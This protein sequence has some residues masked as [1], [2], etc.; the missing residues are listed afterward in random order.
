MLLN[1][2]SKQR[3]QSFVACIVQIRNS[4]ENL[5]VKID[6]KENDTVSVEILV[7][8]SR[9]GELILIQ[10]ASH[11]RAQDD[12]KAGSVFEICFRG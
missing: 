6:V 4:L 9:E 1:L 2:V 3:A 12:D 5:G 8:S 11:R 7:V 10:T